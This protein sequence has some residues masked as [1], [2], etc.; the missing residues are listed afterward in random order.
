MS[1]DESAGNPADI[2]SAT[3]KE[4]V[5]SLNFDWRACRQGKVWGKMDGRGTNDLDDAEI[6]DDVK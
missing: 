4:S 6:L 5:I 1:L 2:T 3:D